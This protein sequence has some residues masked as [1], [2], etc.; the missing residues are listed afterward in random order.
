M[1]RACGYICLLSPT[2]LWVG[3]VW[4]C[5]GSFAFFNIALAAI[6]HECGHLLAFSALR[7]PMPRIVPVARGVRLATTSQLSYG[8]ELI[9]A[10]GGPLANLTIYAVSL[11]WQ[12]KIPC[13]AAFGEMSL[14]TA[15]GNLIPIADLDGERILRCVLSPLLSDRTLWY[16]MRIISWASL[17]LALLLS[18]ILYWYTGGGLYPAM[19]FLAALLTIDNSKK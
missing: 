19:L 12:G 7:L 11:I 18:L 16:V 1:R 4:L 5:E 17:I 6:F 13:L 8:Q 14:M 3:A 15:L 2:I 10:L 9:I